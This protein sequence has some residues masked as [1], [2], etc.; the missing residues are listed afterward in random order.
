MRPSLLGSAL[1]ILSVAAGPAFASIT[2]SYSGP[3]QTGAVQTFTVPT[4]GLYTIL[5]YG[6]S[7]AGDPQ[8][9]D[10]GGLGAEIGDTF[11]LTSGDVLQIEVG[12]SAGN[13]VDG[14]GGGG[15]TFVVDTTSSTILVIAGGGGGG[16]LSLQGFDSTVIGGTGAGGG[17]GGYGGGGGGYFSGGASGGGGGYPGL[18]G[19]DAGDGPGGFGG[20]GGGCCDAFEG[21][22]GGGGG[23][24]YTGGAGG[25]YDTSGAG[26]T[27]YDGISNS[28]PMI[29]V[30]GENNGDGSVVISAVPEPASLALFI[31]GLAGLLA[32]RRRAR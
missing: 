8:D 4:T 11:N 25:S 10:S 13:G 15:G 18:A 20:G 19:G 3:F 28:S 24:G 7:G 1:L 31:T 21:G 2:Y 27:S 5:A 17:S 6:A 14:G 30:A 23:G 12:G 29:F 26:G 16:V 9:N 22:N 32:L